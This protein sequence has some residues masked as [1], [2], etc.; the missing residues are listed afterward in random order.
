MN[1]RRLPE[2]PRLFDPGRPIHHERGRDAVLLLHGWTGWPGRLAYVA[3]RL[4]AVGLTVSVPRLP[5]HGTSMADLRQ[6]TARDWL[7]RAIDAYIDLCQ[8]HTV[9]VAGTSMGGI[10]ATIVAAQF[11]VDRIALLAPAHLT[12]KRSLWVAPLLKHVVTRIPGD[13]SP[14]HEIDPGVL[15]I[16]EEYARYNYL[17]TV[18]EFYRLQRIGRRELPRLTAETLVMVSRNDGAVPERV[19]DYISERSRS[20][21]VE[22][23]VLDRSNHQLGDHVEKET[24]A[25]ELVR[26]FAPAG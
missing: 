2:S 25:D 12:R 13:W 14:D 18:A 6:T 1:L 9:R 16:A 23:I 8:D 11:G 3:E 20:A 10:L 19:A 5:G 7:R 26:W 4:A 24:V 22:S 17:S 21:R 15:P